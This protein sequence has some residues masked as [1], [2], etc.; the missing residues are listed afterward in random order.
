M[1]ASYIPSFQA[2]E[3][4]KQIGAH[5]RQARLR[6]NESEFLAAKRL[7]IS[8]STYQRLEQGDPKVSVGALMDALIL[9]GFERQVFDLGDPDHD[10]VGKR[11]EKL[12]LPKKGRSHGA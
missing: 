2:D 12:M 4:L 8:R 11:L 7:G 3:A 1:K 10:E 5:L 6:R 9:Y